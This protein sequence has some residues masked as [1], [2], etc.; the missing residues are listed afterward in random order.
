MYAIVDCNNFYVSCERLFRPDLKDKAII[1]LSNNDGCV[2]SRSNEAKAL[3]IL[4]GEPYFHIK[5]LCTKKGV[6]VFSSNFAL[7]GNLSDRVMCTMEN[8]WPHIEIY[9]IDEA[10]LDL[11]TLANNL[12]NNFAHTLH[13]TIL[14]H[15]GIPVSIGLGQTKT[16]A[17]LANHVCKKMLQVPVFNIAERPDLL[18]KIPIDEIWGIGKAF[19]LQLNKLKIF[20]AFDLAQTKIR[21]LPL[22]IQRT[23]LELNGIS[24]LQFSEDTAKPK[25]IMA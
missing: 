19:A 16:L 7:Y 18:T 13:K 8:F 25:S 5:D 22:P 9:S 1:V 6:Y 4:M 11:K 21:K 14:Q 15:T 24:A 17:K 12:H 2:I 3:G 23:I 20:T 10:F